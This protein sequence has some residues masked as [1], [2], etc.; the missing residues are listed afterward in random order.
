MPGQLVQRSKERFKRFLEKRFSLRLHMF[1]ILSGVFFVGIL[2]SKIMLLMHVNSM[3]IRYPLAVVFSYLAFFG[4]VKLWLIYLS[5]STG[6]RSSFVDSGSGGD[7]VLPA[8]LSTCPVPVRAGRPSAAAAGLSVGA[9][10]RP[11]L[12]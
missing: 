11:P 7:G 8:F 5:S 3:L 12:T 9:A 2:S 1:L 4:L 10:H 6:R